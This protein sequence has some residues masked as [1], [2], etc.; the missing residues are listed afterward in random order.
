[1]P[2][3]EATYLLLAVRTGK[4]NALVV[5]EQHFP[6]PMDD[7]WRIKGEYVHG[8]LRGRGKDRAAWL[9]VEGQKLDIASNT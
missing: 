3:A 8:L 9:L 7:A 6:A 1:M 4:S 2:V 5:F